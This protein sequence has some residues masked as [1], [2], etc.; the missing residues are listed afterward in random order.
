M[1]SGAV[2]GLVIAGVLVLGVGG[3][4]A[5]SLTNGDESET[6]AVTTP[7]PVET[8]MVVDDVSD[9]DMTEEPT[10]ESA[11]EAETDSVTPGAYV[12]YSE[13]ALASAE[14]TPVLFFHATWCPQ[15]RALDEDI[16]ASG[17]PD[18]IT[19]L[20][21]DYDSNQELRQQYGVTQQTTLVELDSNGE[22]LTTF[23]PYEDPSLDFALAGL[24]LTG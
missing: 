2:V 20:K 24:G 3:A 18:G 11:G 13:A 1:K 8:E 5:V 22:A 7:S 23:I 15:C 12:E 9:D 10:D 19:I 17:V 4:V 21:V 6:V 14:G 16:L